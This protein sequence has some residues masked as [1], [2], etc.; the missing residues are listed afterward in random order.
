MLIGDIVGMPGSPVYAGGLP[1]QSGLMLQDK[2]TRR[3]R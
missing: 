1:L 2:R 3:Y